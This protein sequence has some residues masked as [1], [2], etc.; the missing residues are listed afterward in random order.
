MTLSQQNI[1]LSKTLIN[2]LKVKPVLWELHMFNNIT[3]K[4]WFIIGKVNIN[5]NRCFQCC[6]QS[7]LGI[8]VH[9]FTLYL[10]ET[11]WP[12]HGWATKRFRI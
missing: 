2:R 7:F 1:F 6:P 3:I 8:P 10:S 12:H 5:I 11:E 4:L 9:L